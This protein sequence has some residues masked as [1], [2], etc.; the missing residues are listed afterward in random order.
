MSMPTVTGAFGLPLSGLCILLLSL[1][2]PV[3]A[4]GPE[5]FKD[6]PDGMVQARITEIP[7][8]QGLRVMLLEGEHQGILVTYSGQETLTFH[9]EDR[10]P[11]LR[12]RNDHVEA[13][14]YSGTWQAMTGAGDREASTDDTEWI[15]V[16]GTGRYAWMDPR[17][18]GHFPQEDS[19]TNRALGN[20][21]IHM[22]RSGAESCQGINGVHYWYS[23]N[24]ESHSHG[25][26]EAGTQTMGG[27]HQH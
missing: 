8:V 27:N 13:N 9:G 15:Q 22:E 6:V 2:I 7:D 25:D 16:A 17:L 20:W 12:F 10:E 1:M 18:K 5:D 23:L 24:G 19:T 11:F 14:R 3:H 4:H 26:A 21:H